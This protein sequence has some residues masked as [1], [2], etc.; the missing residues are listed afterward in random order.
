M[1]TWGT[2]YDENHFQLKLIIKNK[3]KDIEEWKNKA[4]L[5]WLPT[6]LFWKEVEIEEGKWF[7][8]YKIVWIEHKRKVFIL[9]E[10]NW[11]K[12][13]IDLLSFK[14]TLRDK[15]LLNNK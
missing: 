3:N 13:K 9:I 7:K 8:T 12:Y 15:N 4:P 11:T 6:S 10:K 14:R 1:E 2:V 5:F